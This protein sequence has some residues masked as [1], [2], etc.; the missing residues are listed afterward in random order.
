M[1]KVMQLNRIS[2][3]IAV[4]EQ[5]LIYSLS[6]LSKC[7]TNKQ[8]SEPSHLLEDVSNIQQV[9]LVIAESMPTSMGVAAVFDRLRNQM[10]GPHHPSFHSSCEDLGS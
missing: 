2:S 8:R 1:I 4:K 10:T 5:C 6:L 9:L 7:P 3:S